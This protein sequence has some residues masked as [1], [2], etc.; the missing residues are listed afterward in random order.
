[1]FFVFSFVSRCNQ[2][3][4]INVHLSTNYIYMLTSEKRKAT[5]KVKL[6]MEIFHL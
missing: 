2:V 3:L 6:N 1:M 4:A 5:L